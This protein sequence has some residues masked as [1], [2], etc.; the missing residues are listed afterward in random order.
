MNWSA[1]LL[2]FLNVTLLNHMLHPSI[3]SGSSTSSFMA[4]GRGAGGLG[5]NMKSQSACNFEFRESEICLHNSCNY[6][7]HGLSMYFIITAA[8]SQ[9]GL[10]LQKWPTVITESQTLN[11]APLIY[12]PGWR[13]ALGD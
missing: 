3:L 2:S 11:L 5:L 12:I 1:A 6:R 10:F 9:K 8:H 7:F 13:E 4:G